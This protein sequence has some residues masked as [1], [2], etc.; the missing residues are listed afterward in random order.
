MPQHGHDVSREARDARGRWADTGSVGS[1]S[2]WNVV[3]EK[4]VMP[5]PL[6]YPP[7]PT[8]IE[9]LLK[10]I[11]KFRRIQSGVG[12][13]GYKPSS[14]SLDVASETIWQL[15]NA[16]GS[17]QTIM[18][19]Y[20]ENI[21]AEG[22]QK[23][24]GTS[25]T[26]DI[27]RF[28]ALV[29]K[30]LNTPAVT[31]KLD[32]YFEKQKIARRP[33]NT[34]QG[35]VSYVPANGSRDLASLTGEYAEK[36]RP[37]LANTRFLPYTLF[38]MAIPL[39]NE[40]S[41]D[42]IDWEKK[43]LRLWRKRIM[44]IQQSS[45]FHSGKEVW[46]NNELIHTDDTPEDALPLDERMAKLGDILHQWGAERDQQV[47]Y[48]QQAYRDRYTSIIQ[49]AEKAYHDAYGEGATDAAHWVKM[50]QHDYLSRNNMPEDF[51]T[52]MP[53][54]KQQDIREALQSLPI[55]LDVWQRL[56]TTLIAIH[57]ETDPDKLHGGARASYNDR[58]GIILSP[59]DTADVVA[60]EYGHHIEYVLNLVPTLAQWVLDRATYS[61]VPMG[62]PYRSNEMAYPDEFITKYVG[63]SYFGKST[64]VLS[65]GI[66]AALTFPNDFMK[67]DPEH[68]F[69]TM[70]ILLGL[71]KTLEPIP[72]ITQSFNKSQDIKHPGSRG[73]H[74]WLDDN[75]HWR[76][77]P[78]PVTHRQKKSDIPWKP[79]MTKGEA[80]KWCA[81]SQYRQPVWHV[82]TPDAANAIRKEGFKIGNAL[83]FGHEFGHGIYVALDEHTRRF[84]EDLLRQ[85][86]V[87]PVTLE[88]RVNLRHILRLDMNKLPAAEDYDFNKDGRKG[89][90]A[91]LPGGIAEFTKRCDAY[92]QQWHNNVFIPLKQRF[93]HA[94]VPR[95][96]AHE[97]TEDY[98]ERQR[99]YND[100]RDDYINMLERQNNMVGWDD[101]DHIESLVLQ[102]MLQEY[103]Y[104]AVKVT[105]RPKDRPQW[106]LEV[107]G[108][109]QMIINHPDEVA[110]TNKSLMDFYHQ[111]PKLLTFL[112]LMNAQNYVTID[113]PDNRQLTR[114]FGDWLW[115][116]GRAVLIKALGGE[117]RTYD[118]P[119]AG[120][121]WITV[122]PNGRE[123]PG[124]PV[125]IMPAHGRK[126]VWHIIGGAG[127]KLT[128]M[129]VHLN[130][131]E[132][133]QKHAA[134]RAK[135]RKEKEAAA[136]VTSEDRK[137]LQDARLNSQKLYVQRVAER[138]GWSDYTDKNADDFLA[139][140]NGDKKKAATLAH[141]Y[142]RSYVS[143]ANEA[144]SKLRSK[145]AV[146]RDAFAGANLRLTTSDT[147]PY[148]ADE[149]DLIPGDISQRMAENQQT[150]N[151]EAVGY[152]QQA[153]DA[154]K[155]GDTEAAKTYLTAGNKAAGVRQLTVQDILPHQNVAQPSG[156]ES[157]SKE[158]TQHVEASGVLAPDALDQRIAEATILTKQGNDAEQYLGQLELDALNQAKETS[159]KGDATQQDMRQAAK[160]YLQAEKF[161]VLREKMKGNPEKFAGWKQM[162]EK[163]IANAEALKAMRADGKLAGDGDVD[164]DVSDMQM[165][166][167]LLAAKVLYDNRIH[168]LRD[169]QRSLNPQQLRNVMQDQDALETNTEWDK[170]YSAA[171]Q[172][173]MDDLARGQD[174]A[175]AAD[176][177]VAVDNP[178]AFLREV[179]EGEP[180]E[181][182]HIQ[183]YVSFGQ[184][185]A[186]DVIGETTGDAPILS[187]TAY[188]VLGV[189]GASRLMANYLATTHTPA[190][191][192]SIKD[193]IAAYHV[194]RETEVANGALVAANAILSAAKEYKR[195]EDAN[196][197]N[198][199]EAAKYN[200][201][202]LEAVDHALSTV[203]TAYGELN[204]TAEMNYAMMEAK[205]SVK[206][207]IVIE[208]ANRDLGGVIE[209]AHALGL[210]KEDY[211]IIDATKKDAAG[212]ST[213]GGLQLTAS[214]IK[215]VFHEATP[216]QRERR[217]KLMSIR[218]GSQDDIM[219][220]GSKSTTGWLPPYFSSW[221]ATLRNADTTVATGKPA[222]VEQQTL[223]GNPQDVTKAIAYTMG[224]QPYAV[225]GFKDNL[226]ADDIKLLQA[227]Y[228]S[229]RGLKTE[230][231][232]KP[233]TIP[234]EETAEPNAPGTDIFGNPILAKQAAGKTDE[235]N[236]SVA[237]RQLV[238][239]VGSQQAIQVVQNAIK[240]D[241]LSSFVPTYNAMT[242]QKLV[243]GQTPLTADSGYNRLTIG[244]QAEQQVA[245]IVQKLAWRY[246]A[247]QGAAEY[248]IPGINMSGR[249]VKQQ[250]VIKSLEESGGLNGKDGGRL[251]AF[252]GVGSGKTNTSIG[253]FYNLLAKNKAQNAIFAMPS[254]VLGQF[255]PAIAGVTD[256]NAPVKW[257]ADPA[258]TNTTRTQALADPNTHIVAMTHESLRDDTVKALAKLWETTPGQASKQF[259]G[260]TRKQ[261][262]T[263][264]KQAFTKM[265]WQRRLDFLSVDEGHQALNRKGKANSILAN[266][267]D[268]ISDNSKYYLP[269]TGTPTRN[270]PSEV[271]DW[272][273]KLRPDEYPP[274]KM[275]GFL[276]RHQ[277]LSGE[278]ARLE[279]AKQSDIEQG[280][281]AARNWTSN[282]AAEALQR[283]LGEHFYSASAPIKAPVTY[284]DKHITLADMP[285]DKAATQKT[286]G[287]LP[288]LMSAGLQKSAYD[289]VGELEQGI[290][291]AAHKGAWTE[292]A[293]QIRELTTVTSQAKNGKMVTRNAFTTQNGQDITPGS[294]EEEATAK[295][296]VM[297]IAMM[298][299]G[300]YNR[301]L[302]AM[303]NGNAKTKALM[304]ILDQ[305]STQYAADDNQPRDSGGNLVPEKDRVKGKPVIVF[306]RS[307]DAVDNLVK[308]LKSHGYN[309]LGISGRDSGA[310][311]IRKKEL[312]QPSGKTKPQANILV[313]SDAMSAGIDLPRAE[314]VI[315]YDT[316]DTSKTKEQRSAR[317]IRLSTKH[318]VS[319][320]S[321][322][323]DTPYEKRR[324]D[325][326]ARKGTLGDV[327][328][329]PAE[330][331][332]DS[333]LGW[334]I[335]QQR[336]VQARQ[337]HEQ[338]SQPS[339]DDL[340]P[341]AGLAQAAK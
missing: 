182:Q 250:R 145:L 54:D 80:E 20:A 234:E 74:P 188:R 42:S 205:P 60:H 4:Q 288:S 290:K 233:G 86:G 253:S 113:Q 135:V 78:R 198:L 239:R 144:M 206:A 38:D 301:V 173:A 257:Y 94:Y 99:R 324:V 116:H 176:L 147:D 164:T 123:N 111:H 57:E 27:D 22:Y 243:E 200:K 73:G 306:T 84:Y 104:D 171:Q 70:G 245:D 323:S 219:P 272:L 127:G 242:G 264:V 204:A 69:L 190:E 236:A 107:I 268:A 282:A 117:G 140:A 283:E 237:W 43:T 185:S 1:F 261:R 180:V 26:K 65:M 175:T 311:K 297:A 224:Q 5:P 33:S 341:A 262:A 132:V 8:E 193:G 143:R 163:A 267:I 308:T 271:Y 18:D 128:H 137:A 276:A 161:R 278:V 258:A 19:F 85:D 241:F 29:D 331:L 154:L 96:S 28:L 265:G 226:D 238:H 246:P 249:F 318:P 115:E 101:Q 183:R 309:A 174:V 252:L 55:S 150:G 303:P 155:S 61:P 138:L 92:Y 336:L 126:N 45:G 162:R 14:I 231:P 227:F 275:Q 31:K 291:A 151:H 139:A 56:T 63:K 214:G 299:D 118:A 296:L 6:V 212:A 201:L 98:L 319:V 172:Q 17:L 89:I 39:Y 333:G 223:Q 67:A 273:T 335:N 23:K 35:G 158:A 88:G 179:G 7:L 129:E 216:V 329:N 230:T 167:D 284:Q 244:P 316:P 97:S 130:S 310:E 334:Y 317:A 215:K 153:L 59:T 106:S 125:L 30:R 62:P 209:L 208:T 11:A 25:V 21:D 10:R 304:D 72:P 169:A 36:M 217:A 170:I 322:I 270:D 202:R 302:H 194:A 47:H 136:G 134:E 51:V 149:N 37:Y 221:P 240:S 293:Q 75:G 305:M 66:Q 213:P 109:N 79:L 295:K 46:T 91:Q 184:Q 315:H 229:R 124:H 165:A 141:Q 108:G 222:Q 274:D 58:D 49:A 235:S 294:P 2:D 68:F 279:A 52:S 254:A 197:D 330:T 285:D 251:G 287:T 166:R 83:G 312:F 327:I 103:G 3:D 159:T 186:L 320:Y 146:D 13:G 321:L 191:F 286:D 326:V 218:A 232:A 178:T 220:D 120:S 263:A 207:G 195:E 95:D 168:Q 82:T 71:G 64:E 225:V 277:L 337:H 34:R 313:M 281:A 247:G 259:M 87:E 131:P 199:Y 300:A 196:V 40:S 160:S 48:Y 41:L 100:E 15:R 203:G 266:V 340:L 187:P 102:Q 105:E 325:R 12:R 81:H 211:Q 328:Q 298:R 256:P 9:S 50:L 255:G 133:W 210:D 148:R 44:A 260:L 289:R 228:A 248:Q 53:P 122:H 177:D 121:R 332:D 152:Y 142:L 338:E 24:Y 110:V 114:S 90:A 119:P 189:K 93:P 76:Y 314:A 16:P 77:G 156:A 32:T 307:L 339:A 292:V 157:T 181:Q 112:I 280:H 269:M 192:Q